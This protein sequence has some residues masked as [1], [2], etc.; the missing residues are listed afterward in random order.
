MGSSLFPCKLGKEESN[1]VNGDWFKR[2]KKEGA[3]PASVMG[4]CE[5][6]MFTWGGGG[7]VAG[8]RLIEIYRGLLNN[9]KLHVAQKIPNLQMAGE[10]DITQGKQQI[11]LPFT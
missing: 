11:F 4:C 7:T 3:V 10:R 5:D 9:V 8:D 6:K 1:K 2:N